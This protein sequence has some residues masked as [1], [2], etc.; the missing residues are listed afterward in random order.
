MTR[1]LAVEVASRQVT[2][3]AIVPG[4]IRT[5]MTQDLDSSNHDQGLES[6]IPLG[7]IGTV[8]DIAHAVI[9]LI[10]ENSSY[11]TGQTLTVDGGLSIRL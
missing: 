3:N 4:W 8:Y 10:S 2:V 7:R 1:A 11:I 5:E 6:T 9:F